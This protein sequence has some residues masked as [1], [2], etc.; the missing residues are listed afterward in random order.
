MELFDIARFREKAVDGHLY[1]VK[2]RTNVHQWASPPNSYLETATQTETNFSSYREY[3]YGTLALHVKGDLFHGFAVGKWQ[4]YDEMGKLQQEVD[5]D[6]PYPFS[7]YDLDKKMKAEGVEIMLPDPEV[8][9]SRTENPEPTYTVSFPVSRLDHA[10]AKYVVID[11]KS[12]RTINT[13][14]VEKEH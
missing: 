1:F 6:A 5:E 13:E 4:T 11:A 14:I 7:I 8:K 12:G 9:V 10:K 3:D 2:D